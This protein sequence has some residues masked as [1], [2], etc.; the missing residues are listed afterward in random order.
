MTTKNLNDLTIAKEEASA[1]LATLKMRLNTAETGYKIQR[2]LA[3]VDGT[4]DELAKKHGDIKTT[5]KNVV[6]LLDAFFGEVIEEISR[7]QNE[8]VLAQ[9]QMDCA[10]WELN[11]GYTEWGLTQKHGEEW[12]E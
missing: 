5:E 9:H 2:S 12:Y 6:A 8:V 3:M 1:K 10:R 7:L 4:V 11:L